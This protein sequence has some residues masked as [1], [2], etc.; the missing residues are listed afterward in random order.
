[1]ADTPTPSVSF[2]VAATSAQGYARRVATNILPKGGKLVEDADDFAIPTACS[3][4]ADPPRGT[5]INIA[6][7][8]T[9]KHVEGPAVRH[10][11]SEF[12]RH[13]RNEGWKK[14]YGSYESGGVA[15]GKDGY[16][17]LLEYAPSNG[18]VS[19]TSQ[20]PCVAPKDPDHPG[21]LPPSAGGEGR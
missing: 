19:L 6:Y 8:Y 11:F 7:F 16:T 10:L 12:K 17:L 9:I 1:M 13:L 15:M 21:D 4:L 3:N 18:L 2:D 20:T 5:P 14:L